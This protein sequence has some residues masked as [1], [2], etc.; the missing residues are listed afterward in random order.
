MI[1]DKS[2]TV[3]QTVASF[4]VFYS[5]YLNEKYELVQELPAFAQDPAQLLHLYRQMTLTRMLDTKAVNLQR[6][7]RMGTYPSSQG[8]E[9]TYVG[10]GDAMYADDIYCASY[11]DQG[12]LLQRGTKISE[13]LA[14]W[15]GD[16]R[17]NNFSV[18]RQD[19]PTCI[20]VS[21]QCLHAAGA[22]F[23]VKYRKEAKAVV[24]CCGDGATSKG[25]FYEA[26]NLA[27]AWHLPLV[28]VIANNQWAISVPCKKQTATETLAQKGIA[29]G[30]AVLQVDGNDVIAVRQAT[31][32]AIEKAR[33]GNGATLIEA[34]AYRL[35]DHTTAD[36]ANRYR[37]KDELKQ[38]WK[39][40]PIARLGYYLESKGLWSR[41][42]EAELH[43][44]LSEFLDKEVAV[45]LK[46]PPAAITDIFDFLYEKLPEPLIDQRE[47]LIKDHS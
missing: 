1:K 3:T 19:L 42:K 46:T 41:D 13:I 44:E 28:C 36:D 17:G 10:V 27:G 39:K 37:S 31:R 4:S 8:Q 47:A 24:T 16:E 5:Q 33:A 32:E 14:V 15:G 38:A 40:D 11:R 23:A 9:A 25:D 45:Y 2:N 20:T 21:G 18:N 12:T 7:G 26:L 22:A 35:A 29:A 43:Q 34:V 6:T 30:I